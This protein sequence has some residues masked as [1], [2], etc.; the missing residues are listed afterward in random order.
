MAVDTMM[1]S[2]RWDS[3][4]VPAIINEATVE[5]GLDGV[6]HPAVEKAPAVSASRE[7]IPQINKLN[8]SAS[9]RNLAKKW[10]SGK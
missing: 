1:H 10:S 5:D 8:K 4:F 6:S 3:I 2:T 9:L 7:N